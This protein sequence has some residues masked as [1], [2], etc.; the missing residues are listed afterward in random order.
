[1]PNNLNEDVNKKSQGIKNKTDDKTSH[2]KKL[3]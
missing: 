3:N 2:D 1:M